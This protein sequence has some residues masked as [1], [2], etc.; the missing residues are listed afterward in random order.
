M[1]SAKKKAKAKTAVKFKD[2]RSKKS[3]RG[4]SSGGDRPQES[5]KYFK[6]I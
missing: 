2:L 5:M 3:P 1:S 6:V 4:G